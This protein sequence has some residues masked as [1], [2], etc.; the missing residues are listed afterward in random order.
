MPIR[1]FI[2]FQK[3]QTFTFFQVLQESK[4]S[5]EEYDRGVQSNA[6]FVTT[7][8]G[9]ETYIT[10]TAQDYHGKRQLQEW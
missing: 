3:F 6:V 2:L 5:D 10:Y 7:V 9:Q 1:F 4:A 8:G